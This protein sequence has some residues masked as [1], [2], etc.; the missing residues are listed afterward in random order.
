MFRLQI[1]WLTM[2]A[3]RTHFGGLYNARTCPLNRQGTAAAAHPHACFSKGCS[4][5]VSCTPLQ[6]LWG[7]K[8]HTGTYTRM[9][10]HIQI[11][12]RAITHRR[13][14]ARTHAHAQTYRHARTH[15]NA[16]THS[17]HTRTHTNTHT[18]T[19]TCTHAYAC[20]R[21]ARDG[22]RQF[23]SVAS[24]APILVLFTLCI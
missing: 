3:E 8:A 1:S 23:F 24:D 22:L 2:Q 18:R 19:I 10:A 21:C 6:H 12:T 13:A 11:Q 15:T 14:H 16:Q 5:T 17:T 9:R 20:T 4:S 7:S